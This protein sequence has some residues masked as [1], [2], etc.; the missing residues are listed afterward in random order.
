MSTPKVS[1]IMPSLN[2]AP[3]I[4]ECIESAV[5]QTLK[6]IE[7]I[8]VDAGST[9]GTLEILQE[10][11]EKD[12][13]VTLIQSDIKSYGYQMNL[14]LDAASGEYIGILE[15]DDWIEPDMFENLW[16]A[17]KKNS[18][19]FVKSN[20]YWYTTKNGIKNQPFDNLINCTYNTVFA[21]E[22][23]NTIFTVT[24]SIWSGIYLREML[25]SNHIRFNETPGASFQDTSFHFMVCAIAQRCYLVKEHYLHYRR[26]N[27]GSSV[28]SKSKVFCIADEMH[29]FEAFLDA[30]PQKRE[31][32]I[33]FYQALK[34]E[35]YR[36]NFDRL[37]PESRYD[38]LR[39]MH[40]EFS[41]ANAENLLQSR[42][43]S[44]AAWNAVNQV[45]HN[46]VV[47]FRNSVKETEKIQTAAVVLK[48]NTSSNPLVSVI[49][50]VCN[51]RSYI[52]ECIDSVCS[53]TLKDIE[54]ICVDDGS[55]DGSLEMVMEFAQ[56]DPR[57]TVVDM[58]VNMGQSKARN[59]GFEMAKGKY[60]YCLDS[61][62][63]ILPQAL[64]KLYGYAQEWNTDILYFGAES[65]FETE[66]MKQE[67][68][69]YIDFYRRTRTFEEPVSGDV[70]LM[71]QLKKWK[72][73]C[74]VPLQF[75]RREYL[76]STGLRFKEGYTHEDE[77]FSCILA[78]KACRVQCVE[79]TL[80]M[81]R[82]RDNSTMTGVFTASKF[83]SL[84]IIAMM[85]TSIAIV[86]DTL[87]R[88]GK[89]ALI[90]HGN[91]MMRDAKNA[92]AKLS[93]DEKKKILQLLPSEFHPNYMER[94][95]TSPENIEELVAIK[96]STSYKVGLVVTF[97][98]RTV[99]DFLWNTK[100]FG[101]RYAFRSMLQDM[102][103]DRKPN[104]FLKSIKE[105]GIRYTI[106]LLFIK[107]GQR[108][109]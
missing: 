58:R 101:I 65:F 106:R 96:N 43:F 108:E 50:P 37:D 27:D 78:A 35:K 21:P 80:Y 86:D 79:D 39:M 100:E 12:S 59:I 70:L 19:D 9:D 56:K 24:P 55:M 33:R 64:E 63:Y 1:I 99:K 29:Y 76:L 61:D 60:I 8:C 26:D 44:L 89:D 75:I 23:S 31:K 2:V 40:R 10:Y 88:T 11:A 17:A 47:Y 16:K 42:Y 62:D 41:D 15:T 48:E 28:H 109:K 105:Y 51:V 7:I 4:R 74:S 13:R 98:P 49:I 54:I 81:R 18:A 57:I 67:Q 66:Q 53:Q 25:V 87:T 95:Y 22:E 20:Y 104:G 82:V 90:F 52:A 34:Y 93:E 103:K 32:L 36:W 85:L 102:K 84:F 6:E 72:F 68:S 94:V 97:I 73:R 83:V 14:G 92:F 45:V 30:H 77:L 3:Y 38:F 5:N 71:D 46:P 91:K 107:L 69:N